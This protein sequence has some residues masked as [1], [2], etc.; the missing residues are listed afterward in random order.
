MNNLKLWHRGNQAGNN[1]S[2]AGAEHPSILERIKKAAHRKRSKSPIQ[3][4]H[5][6][7]NIDQT[8][9]P[10]DAVLDDLYEKFLV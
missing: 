9:I 5:A 8:N 1:N 6:N 7:Q 3:N 2:S 10:E 4:I